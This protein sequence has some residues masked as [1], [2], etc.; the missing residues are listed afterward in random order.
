MCKLNGFTWYCWAMTALCILMLVLG[1]ITV[2]PV[3]VLLAP[4]GVVIYGFMA[5]VETKDALF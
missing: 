2:T 3:V 1:F 5:V 4:V